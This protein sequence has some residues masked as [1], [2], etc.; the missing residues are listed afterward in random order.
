MLVFVKE[1][2]LENAEKNPRS[3]DENQKQTQP[4]YGINTGNRTRATSVGSECFHLCAI[5]AGIACEQAP[6]WGIGRREKSSSVWGRERPPDRTQLTSL[7]NFSLPLC[8]TLV[9]K[10][11]HRTGQFSSMVILPA[12]TSQNHS[13]L[14]NN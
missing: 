10:P 11:P 5:P 7:A 12:I 13:G 8:P 14:Y 9:V 2:K 3:R 1:E 6:K 4:I